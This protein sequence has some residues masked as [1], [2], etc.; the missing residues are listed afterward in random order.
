[1]S[2]KQPLPTWLESSLLAD[3]HRTSFHSVIQFSQAFGTE[4]QC[5]R[6]DPWGAFNYVLY[7][8]VLEKPRTYRQFVRRGKIRYVNPLTGLPRYIAGVKILW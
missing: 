3:G 4:E 7:N 6:Y 2:H 5:L 1:M 8:A